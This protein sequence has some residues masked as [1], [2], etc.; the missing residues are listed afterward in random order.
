MSSQAPLVSSCCS[1]LMWLSWWTSN[2]FSAYGQ[3]VT[4][5]QVGEASCTVAEGS[6][7][8]AFTHRCCWHLPLVLP[9]ALT[10]VGFMN[11]KRGDVLSFVGTVHVLDPSWFVP[12]RFDVTCGVWLVILL[13]ISGV[14]ESC[15]RGY[16]LAVVGLPPNRGANEVVELTYSALFIRLERSS[17]GLYVCKLVAVG[18]PLPYPCSPSDFGLVLQVFL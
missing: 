5:G 2:A 9:M 17:T 6:H 10:G 15:S 1:R 3:H 12:W 14:F 11:T 7:L 18:L 13:V 8:M 16:L 4:L